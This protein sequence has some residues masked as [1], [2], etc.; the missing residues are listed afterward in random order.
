MPADPGRALTGIVDTVRLILRVASLS[1]RVPQ[2]PDAQ[3]DS[4]WAGISTGALTEA[5]IWEPGN[6]DEMNRHLLRAS[7][8]MDTGLPI[9]DVGCGS[10]A[11]TL[12]LAGTFPAAVGVDV[13][14]A[15]VASAR[16]AAP[17]ITGVRFAVLDATA[18]GSTADL[19]G[20]LGDANV[21]VRG[22]FHVLSSRRQKALAESI[23][24]LLG[25]RGRLYLIESNVP[26]GSLPYL[27]GL[28]A[29]GRAI[30]GPLRQAIQTLPKPGHFGP[31]QMARVFP[32]DRW[33]V[34]S[35][36]TTTL[37]T[38][39]AAP[40]LPAVPVP[41]YWAVLGLTGSSMKP[42]AAEQS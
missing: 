38:V 14:A 39:P 2:R 25:A 28:G 34:I 27:R 16:R 11:T 17:G 7:S 26:G 20:E 13:S 23:R 19:A 6:D 12:R 21:F 40:G 32:K 3:W 22:V 36:G 35:E 5:V 15:A 29:S 8:V 37:D 1:A 10:G 18:P 4:F 9:V 31:P 30:P 42:P 41:A 24:T 33:A